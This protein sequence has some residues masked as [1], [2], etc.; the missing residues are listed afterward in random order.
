M[1]WPINQSLFIIIS[2]WHK[3]QSYMSPLTSVI[4][5]FWFIE[6]KLWEVL[7]QSP[8]ITELSNLAILDMSATFYGN[9][10]LVRIWV[11]F[12][13]GPAWINYC[14]ADNVFVLT[15][16]RCNSIANALELCLC[17]DNPSIWQCSVTAVLCW[18]ANGMPIIVLVHNKSHWLQQCG[19]Y[20]RWPIL[21]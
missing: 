10:L 14:A 12:I 9:W 19:S 6:L 4:N 20:C 15:Q 13:D 17:C 5:R 18:T 11:E 7:V 16:E 2:L 3:M 21:E 1:L 8:F